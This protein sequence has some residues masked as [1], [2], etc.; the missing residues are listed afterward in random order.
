MARHRPVYG[1]VVS[2]PVLGGLGLPHVAPHNF[3]DCPSRHLPKVIRRPQCLATC[4]LYVVNSNT[5][6]A[7]HKMSGLKHLVEEVSEPR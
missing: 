4:A 2:R 3:A 5:C 7:H 6:Q 1:E